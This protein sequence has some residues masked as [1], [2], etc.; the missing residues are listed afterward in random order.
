MDTS[1]QN[2][3]NLTPL[4]GIAAFL[5]MVFHYE[6]F[7]RPIFPAS[8]APVL[9]KSYLWVDLFFVLSGFIIAHVYTRSFEGGLTGEGLKRFFQARFARIYPLH[10]ATLAYLV[11]IALLSFGAGMDRTKSPAFFFDF[12]QLPLQL[13]LLHATWLA[14]E[15][16]WNT[17]SWSISTE[18]WAYVC[19]PV[20]AVVFAR[21]NWLVRA[22]LILLVAFA[23]FAIM[24]WLQPHFWETRW[25]RL[26]FDPE[27]IPFERGTIDIVAQSAPVRC[28]AGFIIGM[29]GWEVW[30]SGRFATF[31]GSGYSFLAYC[32]LLIL[33]WSTETLIDPLAVVIFA[34]MILSLAH[35]DDWLSTWFGNRPMTHLGDISY[36]IYLVHMPVLIS[37]MVVREITMEDPGKLPNSAIGY[38]LPLWQGWI[39]FAI[40]VPLVL[41]LASLSYRYIECP[42]RD[43][44]R[45]SR[46]PLPV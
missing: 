8:V 4:R 46:K 12:E 42:A 28:L 36:S 14:D 26:G 20:L 34:M 45:P 31:F 1:P 39:G 18:W 11:L 5:V 43:W 30:K 32:A 6:I 16:W 40:F 35:N 2:I 17:P 23:Y 29:M 41:I 22:I 3:A 13:T 19:F 7:V 24:E 9:G 38:D 33:G 44:L 25:A 21:G 15:P 37:W 27:I 10:F